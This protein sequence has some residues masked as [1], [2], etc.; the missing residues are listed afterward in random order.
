MT[1]FFV[2][3]ISLCVGHSSQ[4]VDVLPESLFYFLK[5]FCSYVMSELLVSAEGGDIY[6]GTRKHLDA[7]QAWTVY[8]WGWQGLIVT[9]SCLEETEQGLE[10]C[11]L[12]IQ[13]SASSE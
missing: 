3:D 6:K 8:A 11:E 12:Y 13:Q 4:T 7:W 5:C 9:S 1:F 2:P 10:T